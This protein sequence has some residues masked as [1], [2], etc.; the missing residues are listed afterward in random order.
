MGPRD[1]AVSLLL[2]NNLSQMKYLITVLAAILLQGS[3]Y[4]HDHN[5]ATFTIYEKG[6]TWLLKVDFT[7][8]AMVAALDNKFQTDSVSENE[9]KQAMVA[10]LKEHVRLKINDEQSVRLGVG[11]IKYA[12][13]NSEAIFILQGFDP[14]WAKLSCHIDVFQQ[15]EEQTNLLRVQILSETYKA[16]LTAENNY[17]TD[18]DRVTMGIE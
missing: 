10:Y 18:F 17:Q 12:S 5:L 4:G 8:S 7:S 14:Q 2:P 16:F 1:T 9:V 6:G 11:G 15:N 3:C 13:H